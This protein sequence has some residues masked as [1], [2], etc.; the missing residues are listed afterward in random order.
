M[1]VAISFALGAII[2]ALITRN[3]QIQEF[4]YCSNINASDPV[5][6]LPITNTSQLPMTPADYYIPGMAS[7]SKGVYHT[8]YYDTAAG[9]ALGGG[10]AASAAG[11]AGSRLIGKPACEIFLGRGFDLSEGQPMP[12]FSAHTF[13]F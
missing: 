5:L 1:M 3:Q 10:A 6:H 13:R 4:V 12:G 2:T 11:P 9:A 7:N 8:N